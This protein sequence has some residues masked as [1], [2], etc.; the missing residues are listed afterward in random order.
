MIGDLDLDC[1]RD[2]IESKVGGSLGGALHAAAAGIG[3]GGSVKTKKCNQFGNAKPVDTATKMKQL[4]A[5]TAAMFR[6]RGDEEKPAAASSSLQQ[7]RGGGG[8]G[9]N[10]APLAKSWRRGENEDGGT[11]AAAGRSNPL[12]SKQ[13][14][15]RIEQQKAEEPPCFVSKSKFDLLATDEDE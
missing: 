9:S 2:W 12:G 4:E 1:N 3:C 5:K 6:V 7:Q 13:P 15:M 8:G 10:R 14:Q 11:A